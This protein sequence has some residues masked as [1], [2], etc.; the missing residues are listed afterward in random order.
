MPLSKIRPPPRNPDYQRQITRLK[1]VCMDTKSISIS[2]VVMG[3]I[4]IVAGML[5][6][7]LV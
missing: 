6:L 5:G 4:A 7:V 3:I 2:G 1:K